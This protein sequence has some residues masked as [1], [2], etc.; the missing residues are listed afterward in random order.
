MSLT[1]WDR[2]DIDRFAASV[3]H[4]GKHS[5]AAEYHRWANGR[6]WWMQPEWVPGRKAFR[7]AHKA[8]RASARSGSAENLQ[9]PRAG[10]QGGFQGI[11]P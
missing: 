1:A 8:M 2:A 4:L 9:A 11:A 3:A 10:F 6:G 5:A 7:E